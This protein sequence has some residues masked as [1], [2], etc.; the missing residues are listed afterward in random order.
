MLALTRSGPFCHHQNHNGI[1]SPGLLPAHVVC[2][3][4]CFQVDAQET[5]PQ[6]WPTE[7]LH[8]SLPTA[9][10][11]ESRWREPVATL[12]AK[13]GVAR[14][15]LRAGMRPLGERGETSHSTFLSH[16]DKARS[17]PAMSAPQMDN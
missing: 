3:N 6:K 15:S 13:S 8:S 2:R 17:L 10:D 7:K 9:K 14:Y 16:P 11:T 1:S 4:F 12:H 5:I